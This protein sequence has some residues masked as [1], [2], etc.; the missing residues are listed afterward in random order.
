[1]ARKGSELLR[2]LFGGGGSSKQSTTATT[3]ANSTGW[4]DMKDWG[5]ALIIGVRLKGTGNITGNTGVYVST[6]ATGTSPSS[7]TTLGLT[8]AMTGVI[9]AA[10]GTIL[11]PNAGRVIFDISADDIARTLENGRYI[12]ARYRKKTRADR[13][14]FTYILMEPRVIKSGNMTTGDKAAAVTAP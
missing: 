9:T 11:K 5:R 8:T 6:A 10:R 14:F 3:A 4:I 1:M 2:V 12:S 7:I 13:V